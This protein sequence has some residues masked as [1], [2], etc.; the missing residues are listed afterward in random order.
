LLSSFLSR[1]GETIG[2][3]VEWMGREGVEAVLSDATFLGW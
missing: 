3:E 1:R 2:E